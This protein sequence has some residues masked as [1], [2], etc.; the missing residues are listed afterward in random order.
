MGDPF[1]EQVALGPLINRRQVERV[2]AIVQDT[3][4]A[5]ARLRAGGKATRLFYRPT[6][7]SEV[8]P[9]MRAFEEEFFG[10]VAPITVFADEAEAIR[11][12]N[13]TDYG[14]SAG[15]LTGSV[16]RGMELAAQLRT[17]LVHINDQTVNDEPWA[18]FGGTGASGNGSRHGGPANWDEFT[19]WQWVTVKP[20][21]PRYPF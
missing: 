15:I 17:G 13:A 1:R 5:G 20:S 9:G 2:D 4:K 16:T 7:L 3:L 21:A 18:P 19:Q 11:L 10:P 8:A 12:A 14:L 6:V